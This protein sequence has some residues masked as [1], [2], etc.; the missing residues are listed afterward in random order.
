MRIATLIPLSLMIGGI[1]APALAVDRGDTYLGGGFSM[2]SYEEDGLPDAEPT[3]LVG[4]LGYGVTD[5]IAIEGRLG[6]GLNSDDVT[7]SGTD[8]DLD[9]DQLAGVYGVAHLPLA[10]RFSLYG[11]A[12]FTYGEISASVDSTDLSVDS[13][14]TDFSYGIGA[15]FG[16]TETISGYIEWAQYFDESDYEVTGIT[17]GANYY[18]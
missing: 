15:E 2:V 14:D 4:R 1:T 13:D 10:S 3:A 6:F 18:F 17:V 9:V 12:G 16:A 7:V 8:L 11:L 5:N